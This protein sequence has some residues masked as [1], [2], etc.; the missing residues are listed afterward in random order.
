MRGWA[1][2]L[3]V[4]LMILVPAA[5]DAAAKKSREPAKA[6]ERAEAVLKWINGYRGE[7][8]PAKLPAAVRAMGEYGLL[9]ELDQA[10]L[11]VGFIAGVLATNPDDAPALI[12]QM[13][14]MPPEDQVILIKAIAFSGLPNWKAVLS[15]FAERMP[16][17]QVLIDKYL[18]G[19]GKTLFELP[20][21]EGSF[22][23]DSHWGYYFGSGSEAAVGRIVSALAWMSEGDS[24]DRLTI[25][26]M[27]KWTLASNATR[28]KDLLDT[29]KGQMNLQESDVARRHLREVILAAETFETAKIRR[30][31]VAAIDQL[32]ARGPE[33]ARN[34]AWW[35]QAGQT[36]LALG[37]VAASAMG[38]VQLGIPCVVGGAV[39][40]AALKYLA[41][42]TP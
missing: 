8:E 39:S 28:D 10:G 31:A 34:Y 20:L 19:D 25:A 24:V 15:A 35:G 36:V 32:K 29:L 9:R 21:D 16:A 18:Y 4:L 14:P 3:A 40:T 5:A 27:A 17:R 23:L 30:D 12:A 13:F 41:P 7:P 11:Q 1:R 38:Q 22:V 2:S 33:S 37:C 6:F 26:A 42:T